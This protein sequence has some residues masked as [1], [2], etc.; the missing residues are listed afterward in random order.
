MPT[1]AV[2]YRYAD[3]PDEIAEHR[4]AHR[5]YIRSLVGA[6]GV[7]ASGRMEGGAGD[8]A[9]LLLSLDSAAE[10]EKALNLDPFWTLG[11]IE[12]REILEWTISSGSIGLD[13]ES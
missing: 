7:I 2:I 5:E 12:S 11:I 8:S 1:F 6:G 4:P 10:V 9:L 13:G 3:K